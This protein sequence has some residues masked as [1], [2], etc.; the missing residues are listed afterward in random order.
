MLHKQLTLYSKFRF[1]FWKLLG[2]LFPNIFD[3]WLVESVY[4]ESLEKESY[5]Y[6]ILSQSQLLLICIYHFILYKPNQ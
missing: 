2:F 4:P 6:L 5:L 3:L 1:C